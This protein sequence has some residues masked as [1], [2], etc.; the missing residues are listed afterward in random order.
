MIYTSYDL[1]SCNKVPFGGHIDTAP[2]LGSHIT[3]NYF[4]GVKRHF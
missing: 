3:Q 2:H 1:I 4:E